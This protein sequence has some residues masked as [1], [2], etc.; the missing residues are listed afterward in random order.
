MLE[1][2]NTPLLTGNQTGFIF[3]LAR[4]L[5]VL[6]ATDTVMLSYLKNIWTI[7]YAF[8]T[9]LLTFI[10]LPYNNRVAKGSILSKVKSKKNRTSSVRE[11]EIEIE[12]RE[13]E[14]QIHKERM[15]FSVENMM[16]VLY[17]KFYEMKLRTPFLKKSLN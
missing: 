8:F 9:I 11:S 2:S 14:D 7:S 12:K 16:Q 6:K 5:K 3:S 10:I 15:V 4:E 13:I 1:S 17:S